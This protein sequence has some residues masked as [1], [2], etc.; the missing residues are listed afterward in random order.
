MAAAPATVNVGGALVHLGDYIYAFGGNS[1]T[2]FWRYDIAGNSWLSMTAAPLAV[3]AGGSLTTDGTLI[4]GFRGDKT[5]VFWSY[6]PGTNTWT[7]LAVAPNNVEQ[8]GALVYSNNFIYALGG[9]SKNFWRYSISSNSW[10]T[11]T[12]TPGDVKEG[13]A[14][15]ILGDNIY[16]F[17]GNSAKFWSY[18]TTTGTSGAWTTTLADT[19][20]NVKWGGALTTFRVLKADLEMTKTVSDPAGSAFNPGES[21]TYT[22]TVT[23]NG[24]DPANEVEV[25]DQLPDEVTYV[26][27][28]GG[29]DYD[30]ITGIWTVGLLSASGSATLEITATVNQASETAGR[31]VTNTAT[32]SAL[33][34]DDVSSN[35]TDD[36]TFQVNGAD[37]AITKTGSSPDDPILVGST[38]NYTVTVTNNGPN[39]ANDIDVEDIL[40]A[41]LNY[42]SNN[43]S[44][45]SYNETTGLWEVGTLSSGA[46][47]T[48]TITTTAASSGVI[49][50]TAEITNSSE[51]DSFLD[52]NI[53]SANLIVVKTFGDEEIYGF[54]GA[55][56]DDFWR[57]DITTDTWLLT[58][59]N[60]NAPLAQAPIDN[61]QEGGALTT[62][63]N[64]IYGFQ[65]R[66]TT[67]FWR[68]DVITNV[69]TTM[70]PAPATV[71][72]GGALVYLDGYIYAFGGNTTTNFWRYDIAANSWSS[73][74][75]APAAV[76]S[77]GALTTDGTFIYGFRGA[78]TT[79]FWRYDPA[80]NSWDTTL[81]PPAT[82][83]RRGGALV[84]SDGYLYAL[85]GEGNTFS[86]YNILTDSWQALPVTPANVREGGA[87]TVVGD[88]IY[89]FRGNGQKAFWSYDV[90]AAPAGSWTVLA[91][92]FENVAWGGALTTFRVLKADLEMSKTVSDPAGSAFD[93]G[94]SLTYTLTV[95][96]LGADPANEVEVDDQLPDEVTFVSATGDGTYDS[97]T[98]IW[99]VGVLGDTQSATIDIVAT[100][101]SASTTAGKTVVNSA[102]ASAFTAD[103]NLSNNTDDASFQVNG[104][105][106]EITKV[107]TSLDDPILETSDITYVITLTNNGPNVANTVEVTEVLPVEVTANSS[108]PSQGTYSST[109]GLWD[110]GTLTVGQTVTLTI[111][112]SVVSGGSI[113]N[114][115]VITNSDQND[116]NTVNNTATNVL[117]VLKTFK[118]GACIINLGLTNS[119]D[120]AL[121]PYGLV[122]DLVKNYKVPIWWAINP[123]KSFG[124]ET[125]KSDDIDF[126]IDGV[127]YRGGAFIISEEFASQPSVQGIIAGWVTDYPDL[128]VNC[129]Q[130]EFAVPI[131]DRITSFS[132]AVLDQANGNIAVTAF[133]AQNRSGIQQFANDAN[134]TNDPYRIGTPLSLTECDDMYIMPHA[135]PS[136]WNAATKTAFEN[137]IEEKGWLWAACHAVGD[138]EGL[139]TWTDNGTPRTGYNLLTVDGMVNYKTH[140]DAT[141]PFSYSLHSGEFYN[142][143]ASDPFMQFIGE[144]DNALT[145]GSQNA[146]VPLAAG[147]RTTTT[148]AL[149]DPNHPDAPA[150]ATYPDFVTAVVAYGR[151]FGDPSLGMVMYQGSH[152][153]QNG[154]IQENI[155]SAKMLGNFWVEAG[156]A[157]RP[158]IEIISG[159]GEA[160]CPGNTVDFEISS[161][162]SIGSSIA[163]TKWT[164][165]CGG[166]FSDNTTQATTFIPPIV[167]EETTCTVTV[168]V[169]DTCERQNFETF[170]VRLVPTLYADVN[171]TYVNTTV[172]GDLSTNN[173][174]LIDK[175]FNEIVADSG[176]PTTDLPTLSPDGT[177][178]FITGVPGV[179]NFDVSLNDVSF[180][181]VGSCLI[182]KLTITV[183]DPASE[184]NPPVANPDFAVTEEV[185]AVTL[186]T[187]ANDAAGSAGL[188]LDPSTVTVTTVL[189]AAT[190]GSTSVNTTTGEITFTP[191]AGFTG[192][193]T[194]T[195]QV[196]DDQ[197]PTANCVISTQ[198]ITVLPTGSGVAVVGTDDYNQT[199]KGETVAATAAEGVLA[200]DNTTGDATNLTAAL[201][202]PAT[203]AGV[204]TLTLNTDGSYSFEPDANFV[205]T[206]VFPYEVCE[207]TVCEQATLY[208]LVGDQ[209]S[210]PD[211][212]ATFV[213]TTVAGDVN[214]NDQVV[215]GTTYGTTP[216]LSSSPASSNPVLT[217]NAD[218]SYSF[219][220]DL[221]GVYVYEVEV[222]APAQ[223]SPCPTELL[224]ITVLDSEATNN[225]PVTAPDFGVMEGY[226]TDDFAT[227]I[228]LDVLG[229]DFAGNDGG[230]LNN[231]TIATAP[232]ASEGTAVVNLD[233]TITFTPVAD[234][235]G[236]VE[237]TYEVCES[238]SGSCRIET[239]IINVLPAD[240]DVKV[241]AAD[242]YN[243][244][245]RGQIVA[246]TAAD[247]V[248]A[249]DMSTAD[250]SNLTA[251]LVGPATQT[252]VGTLTMGADGSYSFE[253]DANFVG[254]AVFPYE[255]CEGSVCVQ[256]TLY[257]LV[258][259][260]S[261]FIQVIDGPWDT[262]SNWK[263]NEVPTAD[264][265]AI[266][267]EDVTSTVTQDQAVNN[268]N[269]ES[270]SEVS[271]LPN[272]TLNVKG[273]I[274]NNGDF[275]LNSGTIGNPNVDGEI[276]LDGPAKQ[277]LS[278]TGDYYNLRVNNPLGVVVDN[279]DTTDPTEI[280]GILFVDNGDFDT[281]NNVLFP[282]FFEIPSI[283]STDFQNG[284][285][286]Q[287]G[288][289]NGTITGD[290]KVEQCYPGRRAFR[291]V[292][293]S[294]T[295]T[296]N[297][298]TNTRS[299]HYNWQENQTAYNEFPPNATQDD[300]SPLI[301]GIEHGFGTHITGVVPDLNSNAVG[302]ENLDQTNGLDWQPS[303]NP[304]MYQFNETGTVLVNTVSYG[305]QTFI[306]FLDTESNTLTAGDPYLI[307]IRGSREVDL[308]SNASPTYNTK[309]RSTGKPKVGA[310]PVPIDTDISA[311]DFVLLG[312]PYHS[313]VDMTKVT[314]TGL[315]NYIY[316]FD[317][318]GGGNSNDSN[319]TSTLE[320]DRGTYVSID[321]N[322][323][324]TSGTQM[325]QYLQ[326]YQGFFMEATANSPSITF[327]EEDKAVR[328][329]QLDVFSTPTDRIALTLYDQN[330]YS[331]NGTADDRVVINFGQNE[332]NDVDFGDAAKFYNPDE[333]L[334]RIQAGELMSVE[335]RAMPQIDDILE[336]YSNNY[337]TTD[338]VFVVD[339]DGLS[340]NNVYLV[341]NYTNTELALENNVSNI[342]NFSVDPS[343]LESI[344]I[345]RFKIVFQSTTFGTDD[346]DLAGI[347]IYP[348]PT[349]DLLNINF[350]NNV[351]RFD[352]VELFDITG[353]LITRR[354]LNNQIEQTQLD[355][356]T[357][358]SGVYLLK[359]SSE[360][361]IFTTKVIVE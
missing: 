18:D 297:T 47:A 192:T 130:P 288:P 359:V 132:N 85:K 63:G 40:S 182:D 235:Y 41:K 233:G 48:L 248:L 231:P 46:S 107:G 292:S 259:E 347:S 162:S 64:Y 80:S 267:A 68:Y 35:N 39:T 294:T 144:V 72:V 57:Y 296:N 260:P 357:F 178:S 177:Y 203:Q 322:S 114:T 310:F 265:N 38:I 331:A 137:F 90:T 129:S 250:P 79:N 149:W 151:A 317:P 225:P 289:I 173:P 324:I 298:D 278:G 147:W 70:A 218:G 251:A 227:S 208:I 353:K 306:P 113:T 75:A 205:G 194:Y 360:K 199:L 193:I 269:L 92:T 4:Y 237:F 14:L 230:T 271:V 15:T 303:G 183:L 214:T 160:V 102:T 262:A 342:Y 120:A 105:D 311:N 87:L 97:V 106:L 138:L 273:N 240:A 299:I 216:I 358:S 335:Y 175:T 69:W 232:P 159:G 67:N 188:N 236:T 152:T 257:I 222:C 215:A 169:I 108:T 352:S 252:G 8:G 36:A 58:A 66:G 276:L 336:L 314:T 255:V 171:V 318:T 346:F 109:T 261:P 287:I 103:D 84:Y 50:N 196:C 101:N 123:Q 185:Q 134:P 52:N 19:P 98:G 344:A 42:V 229:N 157:F 141:P 241:I 3:G 263:Y 119:Y 351:G 23:N 9:N 43:P 348:N 319:T 226:A 131:H 146:L 44:Q 355:V 56:N 316:V 343:N 249:N 45:G 104:A 190:Q 308:T 209:T 350:G 279:A 71:N 150:P 2:N 168:T 61:V 245:D 31:T 6:N 254:T 212:N 285:A 13:G 20:E 238:P 201:V 210:Y 28:N 24:A 166:S 181:T 301:N 302:Q 82:T 62:D 268:L 140:A 258:K 186:N 65:G 281:D 170:V 270:G 246:A 354:S 283:G 305:P 264:D 211:V 180:P 55:G 221:A 143:L 93:P 219:V 27:D 99:T 247:G 197:T 345:D 88:K 74:T 167:N 228:I 1:T 187:L 112:T 326:A 315:K 349:S 33:T 307:I 334:A 125:N 204:G 89:A 136:D 29:G 323:P 328:Q 191:V 195:Y 11:V 133:F 121:K 96:N 124:S 291:I 327:D 304:S 333:N 300:V 290:V 189:D 164:S 184:N 111:E 116:A 21:L 163:S 110:V 100:V 286:G 234:F 330:A 332:N 325:N 272:F 239:V 86:R 282:C 142:N 266:I 313:I 128:Q 22:L 95:T 32:V 338:Y 179:Y 339:V 172:A 309:L 361:E 83:V 10:A 220:A 200:N 49:Y 139:Y 198:E 17:R 77:G 54:R 12:Q 295:T 202:G 165:S 253:P 7:T 174:A 329:L 91:A 60:A 161:T 78:I 321:L 256:A 59:A 122:Y 127:D 224:T 118:P 284:R 213:N 37:L 293:P 277:T 115:A 274:T 135:D 26:S 153:F 148:V 337:R 73:M 312:N 53:D 320:G 242:D 156:A 206:A 154:S 207:G 155:G 341:D 5:D 223:S 16:A 280:N 30:P 34:A 275:T 76:G 176:N 244:T 158:E 340:Q 243:Q 51:G 25:A 217:M 356:S 126:T 145:G 94:E 81:A 117:S